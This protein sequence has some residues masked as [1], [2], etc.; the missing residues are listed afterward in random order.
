MKP[1][2]WGEALL[3]PTR[4][5]VKPL[6]PLLGSIKALAHITGG[7]LSE[8][9]PRVLPDGI[10]AEIDLAAWKLPPVFDWLSKE[11][12]VAEA[13]MLRTFNC[14]IGMIVVTS[15]AN[16]SDVQK[17]LEKAGEKVYRIG[18]LTRGERQVCYHGKLL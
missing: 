12:D 11:G 9:L 5:Y 16:V 3:T 18:K 8:N 2:R 17:G 13:E 10:G 7:G 15:E 14:G 6:L 1:R 4:I